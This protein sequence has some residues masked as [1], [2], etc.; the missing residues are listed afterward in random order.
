MFIFGVTNR[1]FFFAP[2][3]I[4]NQTSATCCKY[5]ERYGIKIFEFI[6]MDNHAHFVLR[7]PTATNLG[8][9]MRTVE[10]QLARTINR[11]FKRDSQAIRER[12][13]SPLISNTKYFGVALSTYG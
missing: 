12:Y 3:E 13:K 5:K 7:T 8:Y 9:F 2:S 4:K 11:H 1:E 6:I 10:S